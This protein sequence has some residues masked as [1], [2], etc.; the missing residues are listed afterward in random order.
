MVEPIKAIVKYS[1]LITFLF[2]IRFDH[3]CIEIQE[4]FWL[5]IIMDPWP[6]SIDFCAFF[7]FQNFDGPL[8]KIDGP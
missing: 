7:F 2:F 4:Y 8:G 1:H 6:S 3:I 5:K